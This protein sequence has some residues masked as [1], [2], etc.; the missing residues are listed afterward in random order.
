M[1]AAM[2]IGQASPGNDALARRPGGREDISF[3][4]CKR[5]IKFFHKAFDALHTLKMPSFPHLAAIGH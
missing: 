4:A 3:S 5:L 2:A 1:S